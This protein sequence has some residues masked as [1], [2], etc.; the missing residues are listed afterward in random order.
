MNTKEQL[1]AVLDTL[2]EHLAARVPKSNGYGPSLILDVRQ[3]SELAAVEV[4]FETCLYSGLVSVSDDEAGD[5]DPLT[6]DLR[7][8]ADILARKAW[9][10]CLNNAGA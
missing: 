8:L 6:G 5:R 4:R 3:I 9:D 7:D 10:A 1:R 2:A